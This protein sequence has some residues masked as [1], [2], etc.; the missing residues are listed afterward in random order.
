MED[1]YFIL[2]MEQRNLTLWLVKEITWKYYAQNA[3][4]PIKEAC[5]RWLNSSK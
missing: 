5:T 4:C 3:K 1:A 2:A